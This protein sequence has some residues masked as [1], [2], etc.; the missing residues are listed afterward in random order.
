MNFGTEAI[1][2]NTFEPAK[3]AN[4]GIIASLSAK[5]WKILK[6]GM[7]TYI[8]PTG[9]KAF[10]FGR[11]LLVNALTIGLGSSRNRGDYS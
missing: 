9:R 4:W 7:L 1:Y 10:D 2:D 3:M 11:G 6:F 5:N 8:S